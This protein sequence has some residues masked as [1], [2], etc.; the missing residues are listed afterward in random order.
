MEKPQD[1]PHP[2]QPSLGSCQTSSKGV[3]LLCRSQLP[4]E[5]GGS[6]GN[7]WQRFS[8][9]GAWRELPIRVVWAGVR[10]L[11]GKEP[12]PYSHPPPGQVAT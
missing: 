6:E 2:Q 1:C 9:S 8:C 5:E 10:V 12:S 11:L 7:C 4:Q 3:Q